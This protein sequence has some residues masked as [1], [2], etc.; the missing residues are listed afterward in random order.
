ME[1]EQRGRRPS[2]KSRLSR[3]GY[4]LGVGALGSGVVASVSRA[5]GAATTDLSVDAT[6]PTV[7][8]DW[9]TVQLPDGHDDPIVVA[10]SLSYH[11]TNP[12]SPRLRD[13]GRGSFDLAV[14]EWRYLDGLHLDETV[15]CFVADDGTYR[16]S[17]GPRFETGR[18]RT[19]HRWMTASF[20]AA[21]DSP[22]VVF[23]NAQTE[24]GSQPVVTR[25]RNV[26]ETGVELRLQEE[27]AGGRHFDETVGYLAVAPGTG[28]IGGNRYEADTVSGVRSDWR[29]VSFAAEYRRPVFLA[30]L[31][32][33]DGSNTAT[34]RYRNLTGSGVQVTVEEERSL[35]RETAHLGERVGYFVLEGG[36]DADGYGLDGFGTGAYG[37]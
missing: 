28:T 32:T 12:A 29:T 19:D 8:H 33:Y 27:E 2:T 21:F 20:D 14:E 13:V 4:L 9:T 37:Q 10:P 26:T 23:S 6:V 11:G 24:N 31:Q 3:R 18:V 30:D 35:D 25:N 15:G 7:D 16:P 1:R 5:A 22:P 34:V 36:A 17:A